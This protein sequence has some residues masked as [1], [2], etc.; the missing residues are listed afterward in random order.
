MGRQ[1]CNVS[2]P[3]TVQS[4]NIALGIVCYAKKS[5]YKE[6]F[7]EDYYLWMSI[8]MMQMLYRVYQCDE[9]VLRIKS[10]KDIR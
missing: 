9:N 1:Y 3:Q 6:A 4:E 10:M 5:R 8:F 7:R 2:F